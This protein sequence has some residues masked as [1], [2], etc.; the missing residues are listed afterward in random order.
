FRAEQQLV[1]THPELDV[2]ALLGERLIER[3]RVLV[4]LRQEL[5]VAVVQ[6]G[7]AHRLLERHEELRGDAET[8]GRVGDRRFRGGSRLRRR[9]RPGAS[10]H[11]NARSLM[12][13]D[14]SPPTPPNVRSSWR[15]STFPVFLVVARIASSSSG[16][17]LRRSTTSTEMPSASSFAAASR[18]KCTGV[19]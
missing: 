14:T 8:G 3:Q 9:R 11:S 5:V 7:G 13:A 12:I 17:M 16:A 15:T 19:P 1:R 2:A 4:E 6:V 18:A 10:S